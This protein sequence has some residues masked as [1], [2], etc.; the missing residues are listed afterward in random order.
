MA[1]EGTQLEGGKKPKKLSNMFY[2]PIKMGYFGQ[3][4]IL[5][6]I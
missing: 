5:E 3:C 2:M 6:Q 1:S 4:V